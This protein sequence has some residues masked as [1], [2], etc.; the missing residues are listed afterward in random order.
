[1]GKGWLEGGK[2]YF[3]FLDFSDY[4]FFSSVS[5][6]FLCLFIPN[7]FTYFAKALPIKLRER[8]EG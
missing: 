3:D 1:M 4:L 5:D 2:R 6:F 8:G 7:G